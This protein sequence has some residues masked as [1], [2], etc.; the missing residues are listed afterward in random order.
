[1][2]RFGKFPPR[3]LESFGV[4]GLLSD[5]AKVY[6]CSLFDMKNLGRIAD[7]ITAELNRVGIEDFRLR[8]FLIIAIYEARRAQF[9]KRKGTLL[10]GSSENDFSLDNPIILECGYDQEKVVVGV[11]FSLS[12]YTIL[13]IEGLADRISKGTPVDALE[14]AVITLDKYCDHFV[15]KFQPETRRVEFNFILGIQ[16][17][18]DAESIQNKQP[19]TVIVLDRSEN[20]L[21]PTAMEYV[22]LGDLDY[23]KLIHDQIIIRRSGMASVNPS[24]D[25]GI[26]LGTP[27]RMKGDFEIPP[28]PTQVETAQVPRRD[29]MRHASSAEIFEKRLKNHLE[30]KNAGG[31]RTVLHKLREKLVG[32]FKFIWDWRDKGESSSIESSVP[33]IEEIISDLD[34][35]EGGSMQQTAFVSNSLPEKL[36]GANSSELFDLKKTNASLQS[37][38]RE[39]EL[40]VSELSR[41]LDEASQSALLVQISKL[42]TKYQELYQKFRTLSEENT[43]V[44]KSTKMDKGNQNEF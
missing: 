6:Y 24:V 4:A 21:P 38:N 37:K 8:I 9:F 3:L 32:I 10:A 19:A 31:T 12:L 23:E 26:Q 39:L 11:S 44:V 29:P 30:S 14:T 40:K 22:E 25:E 5:Q 28:E 15:L 20:I 41:Q 27:I 2:Y 33:N 43:F 42:N 13:N 16:G 1:M 7:L 36:E 34:F 35:L 17:R 18:I